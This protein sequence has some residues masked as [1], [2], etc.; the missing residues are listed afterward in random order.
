MWKKSNKRNGEEDKKIWK[1][2]SEGRVKKIGKWSE[3]KK[4]K[5]K[6]K[7]DEGKKNTIERRVEDWLGL[8]AFPP[9]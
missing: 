9:T 8:T 6:K 1:I 2:S 3:S 4:R 7:L 5:K